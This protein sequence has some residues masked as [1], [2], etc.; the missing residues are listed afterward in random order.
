ML[1]NAGVKKTFS[2]QLIVL[3]LVMCLLPHSNLVLALEDGQKP[4]YQS[5][6]PCDFYDDLAFN[7]TAANSSIKWQV[8]L[9]HRLPGSDAS[10]N[11][12]ESIKEN[13]TQWQ[14]REE[15][16]AREDFNLTNLIATYEPENSSGQEIFFVAH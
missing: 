13:L 6:Q 1:M 14:F 8:D 15:T 2:K 7:S 3:T 10:Y 11:L 9:G 4:N 5:S 12:R 16:H